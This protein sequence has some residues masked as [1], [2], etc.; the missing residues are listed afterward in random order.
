MTFISSIHSS[1]ALTLLK[2]IRSNQEQ[3]PTSPDGILSAA[4]AA[5]LLPGPLDASGKIT[6]ILLESG[7]QLIAG[8]VNAGLVGTDGDDIMKGGLG[9]SFSGGAG[10]D[11]IDAGGLNNISGGAGNDTI[12]TRGWSDINGDSGDDQITAA[13]THNTIRGGA[14]NDIIEAGSANTIDG[15]EG[16]DRITAG[17]SNVVTGGTGDDIITL[18]ARRSE[19]GSN[20]PTETGS[21]I[22]YAAGDGKDKL[23][24][25]GSD[26]T[27]E[28]GE[29]ISAENTHISITDNRATI[30]FDG[31]DGDSI[32]VDL[33]PDS[34][35]TVKF[36][37]GSLQQ[38]AFD[39]GK[40]YNWQLDPR[41]GIKHLQAMLPTAK[42]VPDLAVVAAVRAYSQS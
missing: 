18:T 5:G 8:G 42:D 24:L 7:G 17:A 22:K 3:D 20:I 11:Y 33:T 13:T 40:D 10:N 41:E 25:V 32:T 27:L 21:L 16:D 36:A 37:D 30:T 28:L 35:L 12:V 4:T 2:G 26:S 38:I 34:A 31:S 1:A 39:P 14:G 19:M 15:G 6:R 23:N 29:G 9:S